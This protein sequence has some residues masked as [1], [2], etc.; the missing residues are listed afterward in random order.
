MVVE[1]VTEGLYV[2][3][4]VVAALRS[5]V[6]WEQN[7][8]PSS[9][10][11]M[12]VVMLIDVARTKCDVADFALTHVLQPWNSLQ[13]ERGV[14]TEQHLRGVLQGH[15]APSGIDEFLFDVNMQPQY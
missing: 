5:Q 1:V 12:P 13:L 6:S 14:V 3:Y 7:Y 15:N 10:R 11:S 9:V 2:G 4:V 8:S